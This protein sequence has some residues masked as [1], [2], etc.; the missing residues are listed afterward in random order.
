[1]K[2]K[3]RVR[4]RV[5][6][7]LL[8]KSFS[9]YLLSQKK[10]PK[11]VGPSDCE[12][13][14]QERYEF[15]DAI[16]KGLIKIPRMTEIS[17]TIEEIVT[18]KRS[19]ARF[20]DGEFFI[21]LGYSELG[22]QQLDSA[23]SE[24]LKEILVSKDENVLISLPNT[25]GC[26]D[27]YT[28]VAIRYWRDLLPKTRTNMYELLDFDKRYHNT[29]ITRPYKEYRDKSDTGAKYVDL[30]RIWGNQD[31]F[32]VEGSLSRLGVGNDLFSNVRSLKRLLGPG[33]SAFSRYA[34][35]I[36]LIIEKS[37]KDELILLALG[38]TATVLAY[39][40]AQMGYWAVDIGNVDLDYTWFLNQDEN[41]SPIDNKYVWFL[42]NGGE[43]ISEINDEEYNAEII[44]KM[45]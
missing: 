41:Y 35:L 14:T 11:K 18:Q 17:D 40:L 3:E 15:F 27:E 25:F 23:L 28:D 33:K 30:K 19:L 38:P 39:D 29:A 22:Y 34:E 21:A 43:A 1:M 37:N 26:L 7:A 20:G 45:E 5:L 4:R 2:F 42:D 36:A 10:A 44:H 24:R 9:N 31:V 13:R 8:G 6:Q 12:R 32:L 16:Q